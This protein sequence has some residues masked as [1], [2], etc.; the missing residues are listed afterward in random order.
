VYIYTLYEK[1]VSDLNVEDV[2]NRYKPLSAHILVENVDPIENPGFITNYTSTNG[3]PTSGDIVVTDATHKVYRIL[4][5]YNLYTYDDDGETIKQVNVEQKVTS[6]I[7][8]VT[9]EDR[10]VAYVLTG[11]GETEISSMTTVRDV[12][13]AEN[14]EIVA[15]KMDVFGDQ[16]RVGDMMVIV[17]PQTEMTEDERLILKKFVEEGGALF[18]C[19]DPSLGHELTTFTS[20]LKLY[21]VSISQGIIAESDRTYYALPYNNY[22]I[23]TYGEHGIVTQLNAKGVSVLFPKGA[24]ALNVADVL[25]DTSASVDPFL[26]SSNSSWLEGLDSM[27]GMKSDDEAKGPFNV[28]LTIAK[29]IKENNQV[30][31]TLRIVAFNASAFATYG[32]S[33]AAYGNG[34]LLRNCV[35]WLKGASDSELYIRG[36]T[37]S[38]SI[39]YFRNTAQADWTV[40]LTWPVPVALLLMAGIVVYVKRR[41]L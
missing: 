6:A 39:L 27:D 10:R 22:I 16:Y 32:D 8:Y 33:L 12:L 28:G 23:P 2:L 40:I 29:Q 15:T 3:A 24:G 18:L 35:A 13:E 1:G 20:I 37:I 9:D 25:P 38:D 19:L 30:V 4:S 31:A 26:Y 36:K 17:A 11:H 34:D 5:S 14:F 41:H 7:K 21:G